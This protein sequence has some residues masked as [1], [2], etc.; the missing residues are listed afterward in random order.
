MGPHCPGED[1]DPALGDS[2]LPDGTHLRH[3]GRPRG[4]TAGRMTHQANDTPGDRCPTFRLGEEVQVEVLPTRLSPLSDMNLLANCPKAPA[5]REP[6]RTN[7]RRLTTEHSSL[8][9]FLKSATSHTTGAQERFRP[10]PHAGSPS[11][12]S[13]RKTGPSSVAGLRVP[14]HLIRA[15][16]PAPR[17]S[18]TPRS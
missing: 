4:L 7:P 5:H 12:C 3:E 15:L 14:G 6:L 13:L 8:I 9:T 18:E 16:K 2:S 11:L 1:F 17:C 10:P